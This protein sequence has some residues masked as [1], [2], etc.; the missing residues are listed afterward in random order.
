MGDFDLVMCIFSHLGGWKSFAKIVPSQLV[1]QGRAVGCLGRCD[2]WFFG[3]ALRRR[4]KVW[5]R[6]VLWL[7]F[8]NPVR[9]HSTDRSAIVTTIS[10]SRPYACD[11]SVDRL[12]WFFQ[13]PN[14]D[15][16]DMIV[17]SESLG[18]TVSPC[19]VSPICKCHACLIRPGI[20]SYWLTFSTRT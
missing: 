11:D 13:V 19:V 7:Q 12:Y 18:Y 4:R 3:R 8:Y 6:C 14:R 5:G 9:S 2:C 15:E 1:C 16:T 20:Q 10:Q 17:I